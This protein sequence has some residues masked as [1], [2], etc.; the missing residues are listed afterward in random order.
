MPNLATPARTRASWAKDPSFASLNEAHCCR[1]IPAVKSQTQEISQL[2]AMLKATQQKLRD[3]FPD[4]A[5]QGFLQALEPQLDA[6][7]EV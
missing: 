4:V 3:L 5:E 2:I 6:L 7:P 1:I